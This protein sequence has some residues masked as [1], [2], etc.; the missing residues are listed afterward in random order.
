[1]D[2]IPLVESESPSFDNEVDPS[3]LFGVETLS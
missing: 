1:M 2:T 3:V